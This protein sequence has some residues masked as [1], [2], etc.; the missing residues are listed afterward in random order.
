MDAEKFEDAKTI[1]KTHLQ[2][3]HFKEE[4]LKTKREVSNDKGEVDKAFN[5]RQ[6][7]EDITRTSVI[8]GTITIGDLT[9]ENNLQDINMELT[10][11]GLSL[12]YPDDYEDV[13]KRGKEMNITAKKKAI[14]AHE[15]ALNGTKLGYDSK[16]FYPQS[17]T[18]FKIIKCKKKN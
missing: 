3:A 14:K 12:Q 15:F 1:V 11:R 7:C 6:R 8:T 4:R 13:G 18:Q 2:V 17:S 9:K 5:K 10:A 16:K